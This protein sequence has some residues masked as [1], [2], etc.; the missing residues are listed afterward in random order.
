MSCGNFVQGPIFVDSPNVTY[1][2][3]TITAE[4]VY[5]RTFVRQSEGKITVHPHQETFIIQTGRKVPKTGVMLVGWGGNNGTTVTAGILANRKGLKWRTKDGEKSANYI[6]SLTQSSTVQLGCN[7]DGER[8]HL[9]LKDLLPMVNPNDLVIG[10]WDISARPL[11][12]AMAAAK[13][14]DYD[15]QTQL[16]PEMQ[17]LVPL[18]SLYS[19]DFIAHNQAERATNVL[20]GS[21]QEQLDKIR[22]D[23]RDFK[24]SNGLEAVL[25]MWTANTERFCE[26][27]RRPPLRP[28][29]PA[30]PRAPALHARSFPPRSSL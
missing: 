18:P 7:D 15:L 12:D 6:G 17:K 13:V 26:V 29:T 10:G 3:D 22:A 23:I 5:G 8:V 9:P 28:S 16:Y 1:T 27:R 20:G 19:P 25:L 4:Y 30:P 21:K 11:G 14:L 2:D 24:K